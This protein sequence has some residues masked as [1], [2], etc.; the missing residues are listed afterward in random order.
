MELLQILHL[1]NYFHV[2][3][4]SVTTVYLQHVN[5]ISWTCFDFHFTIDSETVVNI[6]LEKKNLQMCDDSKNGRELEAFNVLQV[7]NVTSKNYTKDLTL[8]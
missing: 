4:S 6:F 1:L 7:S 8:K 5:F 2:G 3:K